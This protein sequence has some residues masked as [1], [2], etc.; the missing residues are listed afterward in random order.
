MLLSQRSRYRQ[1]IHYRVLKHLFDLQPSRVSLQHDFRSHLRLSY[2][3]VESVSPVVRLYLPAPHRHQQLC[4]SF[5]GLF[6]KFVTHLP[7]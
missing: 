6:V 1:E 3:T 2:S 7:Q 5:R 4:W